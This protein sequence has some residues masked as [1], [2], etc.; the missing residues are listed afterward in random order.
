MD[1]FPSIGPAS[2]ILDNPVMLEIESFI[3]GLARVE[4]SLQ[5]DLSY[6]DPLARI[7]IEVS[8]A[9]GSSPGIDIHDFDPTFA[10]TITIFIY[11]LWVE[12]VLQSV[13]PLL[14]AIIWEVVD[15]FV[16][17]LER[18][19]VFRAV[20]HLFGSSWISVHRL[21]SGSVRSNARASRPES[22]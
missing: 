1:V 17:Q 16:L 4:F 9:L 2:L 8:C 22:W 18:V 19:L 21:I 6:L 7:S 5:L 12:I 14:V 20:S 13:I 3:S 11:T 15:A 10:V